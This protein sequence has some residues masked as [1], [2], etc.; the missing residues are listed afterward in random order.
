MNESSPS[1][2][3]LTVGL[4]CSS[5]VLTAGVVAIISRFGIIIASGVLTFAVIVGVA[6]FAHAKS[7]WSSG[8][9]ALIAAAL[10]LFFALYAAGLAI[11]RSLGQTAAGGLLIVLAVLIAGATVAV[12]AQWR[13]QPPR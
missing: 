5:L 11:L 10:P 2:R 12:C 8:M 13:R 4:A 7:R 3:L 1:E 9:W 6:G